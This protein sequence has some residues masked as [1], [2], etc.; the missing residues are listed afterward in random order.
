MNV[1]WDYASDEEHGINQAV[2]GWACDLGGKVS[3]IIEI[4]RGTR[5]RRTS[6]TD[7]G[8]P[9]V[10]SVVFR[11]RGIVREVRGMGGLTEAVDQKDHKPLRHFVHHLC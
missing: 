3:L 6:M 1:A 7:N 4:E 11:E 5:L 9:D 2:C 8:G 10:V